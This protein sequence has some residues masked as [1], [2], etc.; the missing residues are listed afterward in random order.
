MWIGDFYYQIPTKLPELG[1]TSVYFVA[2]VLVTF[3]LARVLKGYLRPYVLLLANIIF[4]YSFGIEV[5]RTLAIITVFTYLFAFLI[6]KE[7]KTT[8]ILLGTGILV[9]ILCIFKYGNA[10][11]S[12]SIV[13]PLGL[14][15]YTFKAISYL[16]DIYKE[17]IK[18]EKNP[19]YFADY[20]MFFPVLTAGPINR[21]E[22]FLKE[23]RTY[24][25]LDYKEYVNGMFGILFGIF[26]KMVMC[27]YVGSVSSRIL[28]NP[29]IVGKTA[30]FGIVLYS[31]QIYLDFDSISNTSIGA[32][33]LLGFKIPKNF[34]SP[35]LAVSLKDFWNRWHISLST[36]LKDYIYIPLGGNRK[37]QIRMYLNVLA[38]FVVSGLWHGST[39]NFLLWGILHGF[40][41]I[42]EDFLSRL[43][44]KLNLPKFVNYIA[45]PFGIVINF[46]IVT[47]LWLIFKYQTLGEVAEVITRIKQV[48]VFDLNA[49]GMTILEIKWLYIILVTTVVL[50]VVR[51][52]ID[53]FEKYAVILFPF[54]W[55]IYFVMIVT[56]LIFGQYGGSFDANDFIYRWF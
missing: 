49:I 18:S 15:F 7:R 44:K 52:F 16:V 42:A 9:F 17:K 40:V 27:D 37:G 21:A 38:V 29:E 41:R 12:M 56:F 28:S 19:I 13:A 35:Y 23:I 3:V 32:A 4:A 33:K 26:E 34:N 51:N 53:V 43:V 24:R 47:F 31:F 6:E 48:G 8:T 2:F 10:I 36:W 30:L 11:S 46:A 54:R 22:S 50:D 39:W 1:V 20:L 14:S 55:I 25:Q 45:I 5:L